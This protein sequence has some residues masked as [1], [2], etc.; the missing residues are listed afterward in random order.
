[1]FWVLLAGTLRRIGTVAV[2]ALVVMS[3]LSMPAPAF[4]VPPPPRDPDCV[5]DPTNPDCQFEGSNIP[6][7]PEDARCVSMPYSIGCEGGSLDYNDIN[8]WP[9]LPGEPNF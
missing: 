6:T 7:G 5:M 8:D 1:M 2:G 4:A 3:A 9:R